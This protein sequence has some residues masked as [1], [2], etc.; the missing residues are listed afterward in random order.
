VQQTSPAQSNRQ[1]VIN[2]V[3]SISAGLTQ[4]GSSATGS[5]LHQIA[6]NIANRTPGGHHHPGGGSALLDATSRSSSTGSDA[7]AAS[8]TAQSD[9]AQGIDLT[10]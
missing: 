5:H 9:A 1:N 10:A 6:A 4:N 3:S 8:Q 2:A 7:G